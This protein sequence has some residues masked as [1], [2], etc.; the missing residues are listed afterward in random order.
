MSDSRKKI[1]INNNYNILTFKLWGEKNFK[2]TRY[3]PD[4]YFFYV[5]EYPDSHQNKMT[6]WLL[7]FLPPNNIYRILGGLDH[8]IMSDLFKVSS[9][10]E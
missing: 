7:H 9:R 8:I 2:F 5:S 3:D 1:Q 6:I 10:C 4:P